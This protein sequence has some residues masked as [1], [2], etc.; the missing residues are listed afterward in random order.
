M[1]HSPAE[2]AMEVGIS[3]LSDW[4]R[5]NR[6]LIVGGK[7]RRGDGRI[8]HAVREFHVSSKR[9][10]WERYPVLCAHHVVTG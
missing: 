8:L 2:E 7:G 9:L 4:P 1:C 3:Y 6:L 10:L 5:K